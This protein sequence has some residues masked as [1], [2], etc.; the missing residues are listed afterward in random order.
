MLKQT[1]GIKSSKVQKFDKKAIDSRK[2][3]SLSLSA[4]DWRNMLSCHTPTLLN[5]GHHLGAA[6]RDV[7]DVPSTC[8]HG[9]EGR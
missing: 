4:R 5:E 1:R 8:H 3:E 6:F 2:P 7:I 9:T